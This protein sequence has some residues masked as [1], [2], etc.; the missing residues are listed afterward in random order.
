[1]GLGG[2]SNRNPAATEHGGPA[3][4]QL[5]HGRDHAAQLV[6]G[7]PPGSGS[8]IQCSTISAFAV[9]LPR[10]QAPPYPYSRLLR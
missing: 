5:A 7:C 4:E 1:M 3:G 8:G 2:I 9:A 10:I 6:D